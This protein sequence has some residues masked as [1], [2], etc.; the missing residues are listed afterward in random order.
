MDIVTNT[1]I[2]LSHGIPG[3]VIAGVTLILMFLALIRKEA[4][5][6]IFAAFLTIPFAYALGSWWNFGIFVRL[7]PLFSLGSAFA[8]EKEDSIFSWALSAPS[9]GYLIY[10]LFKIL[11]AGV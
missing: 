10:I 8:I 1:L 11:V 5:L 7:L 9:F 6:M 4:G 3:L 2:M